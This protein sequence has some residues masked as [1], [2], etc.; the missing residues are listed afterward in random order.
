M[1]AI[2]PADL[3]GPVLS[4]NGLTGNSR[5]RDEAASQPARLPLF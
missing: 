2:F 4:P 5:T 3:P 1:T